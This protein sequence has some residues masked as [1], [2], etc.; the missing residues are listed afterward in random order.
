M[1]IFSDYK[2]GV[3]SDEEFYNECARMNNQE[4]YEEQQ[5]EYDDY[6]ENDESVEE[7]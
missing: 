7:E 4:R 1:S 2:V 5:M 6:Y 3:L